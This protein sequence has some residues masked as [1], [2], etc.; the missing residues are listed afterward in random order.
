ML[1]KGKFSKLFIIACICIF[2]LGAI[3]LFVQGAFAAQL[4]VGLEYAQSTGLGSQ[5]IR[6]VIANIIRI[7]LGFLG[8]I[9]VAL[10][11]YAGWLWMSSQGN[12]EKVSK[13]KDILKNAV[14]G[15]VIILSA[16]AIASFILNRLIFSPATFRI[17][18]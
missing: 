11:I 5:D 2:M 17:D 16:F 4:N 14:I 7:I 18:Q 15:L 6:I 12:E 3:F 13:A 8:I 9:F 10:I 1:K